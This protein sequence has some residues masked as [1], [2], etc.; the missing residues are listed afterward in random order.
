MEIHGVKVPIFAYFGI[1][2][3]NEN[4]SGD[5]LLNMSYRIQILKKN[6]N[7]LVCCKRRYILKVRKSACLRP[8][9]TIKNNFFDKNAVMF[10]SGW[11]A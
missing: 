4:S 3:L 10:C 7:Y 6:L 8:A 5:L 2:G 9:H 1:R 11:G